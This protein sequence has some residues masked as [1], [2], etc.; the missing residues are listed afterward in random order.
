V[1]RTE[2]GVIGDATPVQLTSDTGYLDG[3]AINNRYWVFAGGLTDV[4]VDLIVTDYASGLV[5]TYDNPQKA[6]FQPVQD[7]S[8]FA[9]CP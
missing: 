4:N 8:A 6:A 3:C 1:F 9:T 7:T 5:R 2:A